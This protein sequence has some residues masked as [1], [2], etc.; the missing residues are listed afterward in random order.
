M[1]KIEPYAWS[2]SETPTTRPPLHRIR[3]ANLPT[4]LEAW[5][6][7]TCPTGTSMWLVR[8]DMTG[9]AL[10][11]NKVRKL[12]FLLADALACGCDSILTCGGIQSNHARATAVAAA[13]LGL[14]SHLYLRVTDPAEDPGRDGNLL[15]NHQVGAM[16]HLITPDQYQDRN[17]HMQAEADRLRTLGQHPYIIPEGGSNALGCWGYI[18][19]LREWN[20]HHDIQRLGIT[21][22]V[23]A[24][25]SGGTAAG[26]AAGLSLLNM[27]IRLHAVNV[28][29]DA[30]YFHRHIQELFDDLGLTIDARKQIDII[31]GYVGLG[32]AKSRSEELTLLCDV[33]RETGILLDPVYTGKAFMALQQELHANPDR[34]QGH[35]ILFVHTGGLFGLYPIKDRLPF[36]R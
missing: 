1:M 12:E 14:T 33:A 29:D 19:A 13:R 18:E 34:F 15:L 2:D 31:D 11:G 24:L 10:S 32:Y 22:I 27:P 4:P 35:K 7:S 3:L 16:L 23:V 21:D 20:D 5:T 17:M 28:C 30:D 8:D 26:L 25:G 36:L 9:A 6:P